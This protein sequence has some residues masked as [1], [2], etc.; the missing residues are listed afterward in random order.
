MIS[1]GLIIRGTQDKKPFSANRRE[2]SA[3]PVSEPKPV[4]PRFMWKPVLPYLP[5]AGVPGGNH[6]EGLSTTPG[7]RLTEHE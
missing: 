5:L 2:V 4:L 6:G 1:S 3:S 7:L